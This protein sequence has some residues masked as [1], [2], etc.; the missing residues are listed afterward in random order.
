MG[1][2]RQLLAVVL[3]LQLTLG[4]GSVAW[5]QGTR[6]GDRGAGAGKKRTAPGSLMQKGGRAGPQREGGGVQSLGPAEERLPGGRALSRAVVPDQYILGPGDGLTI[7][8]WGEYE[9]LSEV[10]VTADGKISLPTLG[11]LKVKGLSLAQAESLIATEVKK[12]YRN[13]KSGLSLT[14]LR[15]F[16]VAVL[17]AV[18]LPGAYLATP[19]KR[20]SDVVSEAGGVLNGGS[21]RHIEVRRE[22]RV[23]TTADLTAF[24][25]RGDES[26]NPE[27]G[28]VLDGGSW[29]HIEVRREGRVV[30]TADL[31]AFFRHGDESANPYLQDGDVIFVPPMGRMI[32]SVITN[33]VSV[34]AQS[35]QVIENSTPHN[36]EMNEGDQ[37]ADLLAELGGVSPWWNLEAAYILRETKAPEGTMKIQVDAKRL[38]FEGDDTKNI[39]MHGG[40]QVFIPSNVRRVFVNGLVAKGGAF[41][42]VPNRTAEEYLGLAGGVQLQANLDRSTIRRADGSVEP[43]KADAVLFNGDA[44]QIVPKY[45]ATPSDYIGIIGGL[46]SLVFSAFAFLTT[47]K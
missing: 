41:A 46:T 36:I 39:E 22:G 4:A 11:D 7:N 12:Y 24:F 13:V 8:L 5:A 2:F 30:T 19:V 33:D 43:F 42:Y 44:L 20:V 47:L 9:D 35:G 27:A 10:R 25:R 3:I 23:V 18:Q 16:E 38:I 21:W 15:V 29:R 17:G 1:C 31:T 26:A 37:V 34:S 45:F 32:V 28:G 14:L 6:G 40:D